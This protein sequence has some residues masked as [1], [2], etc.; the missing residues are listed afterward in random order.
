MAAPHQRCSWEA[1][2][3]H[4]HCWQLTFSS[5]IGGLI[6]IGSSSCTRTNRLAPRS[7]WAFLCDCLSRNCGFMAN[8]TGTLGWDLQREQI[9]QSREVM[10]AQLFWGEDKWMLFRE[11]GWSAC[12]WQQ[13]N[14]RQRKFL[15][16]AHLAGGQVCPRGGSGSGVQRGFQVMH[17]GWGDRM[18]WFVPIKRGL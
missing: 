10:K 6:Q 17:G 11:T 7:A 1:R 5:Y 18:V 4:R 9:E 8:V 2:S 14:D 3:C 15:S 13:A 16:F 12:I